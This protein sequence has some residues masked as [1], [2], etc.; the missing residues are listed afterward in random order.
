MLKLSLKLPQCLFRTREETVRQRTQHA[1]LVLNIEQ[2]VQITVTSQN[3][4]T[5]T[6]S[7]SNLFI[8]LRSEGRMS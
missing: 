4:L 3:S 6:F 5:H 1:V 2:F 7:A 8:G